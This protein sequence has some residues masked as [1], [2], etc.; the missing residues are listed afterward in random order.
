M[1]SHKPKKIQLRLDDVK[2]L[3]SHAVAAGH[4]HTDAKVPD[5]DYVLNRQVKNLVDEF[6]NET[7]ENARRSMVIAED[8]AKQQKGLA[9]LMS[10]SDTRVEPIDFA[11]EKR[12]REMYSSVEEQ[13][14]KVTKLRKTM[15]SEI[16][17]RGQEQLRRV[18]ELQ[19]QA[20]D[21]MGIK[22]SAEEALDEDSAEKV[23]PNASEWKSAFEEALNNLEKLK[24]E[25]PEVAS[26]MNK[27]EKIVEVIEARK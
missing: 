21:D 18:D 23:I 9:D 19:Q 13:V 22:I 25:A 1:S 10:E 24:K 3:H 11:L 4:R 26:K 15:P 7:F 14:L 27:L 6:I 12:M 20:N 17:A 5:S 2:Y 16:A 8:S